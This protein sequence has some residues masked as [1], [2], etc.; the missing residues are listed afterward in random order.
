MGMLKGRTAIVVGASSGVGYGCALRYA[1]EGANV[2]ACSNEEEGLLQLAEEAAG[3]EGKI[4]TLVADVSKEEDLNNIVEKTISE[5]GRIEILACIA[6]GGLSHPTDLIHATSEYALES[7][8]T[9]PLYTMLLMQKC[10][11]YMKEQ[12]YGRIITTSSGGAVSGTPGFA[13]YAMAK[14][15]IMSL[16]RVAAKEWAQYGITTNCFFPVIKARGFD[17]TPQGKAAMEE[18][19]RII[20]VRYVGEAYR[21]CSPIL[22][23]MASEQAHYMNGQMIGIDGGL[24]LLA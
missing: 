9:G 16:T 12:Q 21:D 20:P 23:F 6:Q 8:T 2:L 24:T 13:S 17:M 22:A 1:E 18:L 11:P 10:F 15:A 7:Y 4:V 5:F 3:L 19:T 14:G